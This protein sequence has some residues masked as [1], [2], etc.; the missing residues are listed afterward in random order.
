MG[1][2]SIRDLATHAVRRRLADPEVRKALE[3]VCAGDPALLEAAAAALSGLVSG[4]AAVSM[5]RYHHTDPDVPWYVGE[6]HR[7]ELAAQAE[8]AAA[9]LTT[10]VPGDLLAAAVDAAIKARRLASA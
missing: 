1:V 6:P 10:P 9:V 7:H 3:D 4:R 2:M 5:A 8:F